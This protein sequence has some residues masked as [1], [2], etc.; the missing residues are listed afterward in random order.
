MD[1]LFRFYCSS[2]CFNSRTNL[3][4]VSKYFRYFGSFQ[5]VLED[6]RAN[7]ASFKNSKLLLPFPTMLCL[8]SK[9]AAATIKE[10]GHIL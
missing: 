8:T 1:V 4:Y 5:K 3:C 2:L 9:V 10:V 7:H 6:A